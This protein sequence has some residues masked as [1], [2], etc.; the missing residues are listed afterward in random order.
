M[1]ET[2]IINKNKELEYKK[3]TTKNKLKNKAVSTS[4]SAHL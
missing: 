3:I 4:L 1:I 2:Q